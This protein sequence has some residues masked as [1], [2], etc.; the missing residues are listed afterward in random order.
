MNRIPFK[1]YCWSVGTT[2]YRTGEFSKNIEWQLQL[3]SDFRLEHVEETWGGNE[4]LQALYYKHL[5]ESNFLYGDAKRPAKD[6]REKTSGLVSIGLIDEERRL[7]PVGEKL[8]DISLNNKF[9]SNNFFE[10]P[11]DSYIYFKQLIKTSIKIE[12]E[13]V[14]PF[15]VFIYM[16]DKLKFLTREEFT[17][18]LPLCT[19]KEITKGIVEKIESCRK[20]PKKLND[21]I[22]ETLLMKDNYKQAL[23]AFNSNKIDEEL[24]CTVGINRK[25]RNYDKP[26]YQIYKTLK[27]IVLKKEEA[28]SQLW[29]NVTKLS[30]GKVAILWKKELFKKFNKSTI[31]KQGNKTLNDSLIFKSKTE[32]EFNENFFKL[33]H[34]FK[35]KA[36]LEDYYDLNKRYFKI[37][38]TVIF[39]DNIVE[40]AALPKSYIK[41]IENPLLDMAFVK[42]ELLAKDLELAEI[43]EKFTIKE[44]EV[45][46]NLSQELGINVKDS[47][48]AKKAISDER[49]ARF[50]KLVD[51]R[52]SANA[53]IDIFT[54]FEKREDDE[55]KNK[56]TDNADIP[57]MFEYIL[58]IAWYLISGRKGDVLEYMNLSLEADLLPRSHAGGGQADIVWE[59][60]ETKYYPKHTLL[61]E[62]TLSSKDGQR[63]ME[64]EPVSRHLGEYRLKNKE[65]NAYC[66]FVTTLLNMN[67]ISDFRQR[68]ESYYYNQSGDDC[69]KGL[70]IIPLQTDLIKKILE[71]RVSYG[72]L[73]IGFDEAYNKD[74]KPK[75]WYQETIVP[76]VEEY[77]N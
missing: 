4:E 29:R 41:T 24:I 67:V 15:L 38:D 22:I 50:N 45:Y 2:S 64:M 48:S 55:L 47:K 53:L 49:Y 9:E 60:E 52:F 1:S 62:A 42:S 77:S 21:V 65:D 68:K 13:Y 40:L 70:K 6:A 76:I 44:K 33:M 25:S 39:E 30:N 5:K 71:K 10:I 58:G 11:E 14:R 35:A 51:D 34:L 36:T 54:L 31:D 74:E 3:L 28:A 57:T 8:L 17:Y 43:D 72:Q 12:N 69:V 27:Q 23:K 18:L 66:I 32:K 37:T 59:Y 73:Y 46:S 75:E 7:T 56:I 26:Y 61:L 19:S 16:I 20:N 63:K